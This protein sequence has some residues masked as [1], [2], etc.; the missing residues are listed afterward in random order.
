MEHIPELEGSADERLANAVARCVQLRRQ[1]LD[2]ERSERRAEERRYKVYGYVSVLGLLVLLPLPVPLNLRIFAGIAF[3]L[4]LV[5]ALAASLSGLRWRIPRRMLSGEIATAMQIL[6]ELPV[7]SDEQAAAIAALLFAVP[8]E[9]IRLTA[10][11]VLAPRLAEACELLEVSESVELLRQILWAAC[12]PARNGFPSPALVSAALEHIYVCSITSLAS[13]VWLLGSRAP[14]SG[15]RK[16]AR[17][18]WQAL[19]SERASRRSAGH[20]V[21]PAGLDTGSEHLSTLLKPSAGGESEE[22]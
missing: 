8:D 14:D 16:T 4:C 10:G 6:C 20:L 7:E 17:A 3:L 22:R 11:D 12:R 21:R 2:V 19:D 1:W 13:H 15:Q 18:V 9:G 5:G